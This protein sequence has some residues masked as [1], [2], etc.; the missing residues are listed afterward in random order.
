MH[1]VAKD[2][3][4]YRLLRSPPT[5]GALV[6]I[7]WLEQLLLVQIS[8]RRGYGLAESGWLCGETPEQED[9]HVLQGE[10]LITMQGD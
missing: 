4:L 1:L 3:E 8:Y 2:Y 6:G 5:H 10:L 7:W 9:V